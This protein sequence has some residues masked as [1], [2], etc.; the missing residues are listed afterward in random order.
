MLKTKDTHL[1]FLKKT[2]SNTTKIFQDMCGITATIVRQL[3]VQNY[4]VAGL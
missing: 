4:G 2:L 1:K 3:Q